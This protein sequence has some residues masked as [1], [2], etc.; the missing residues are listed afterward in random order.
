MFKC[1]QQYLKTKINLLQ[2]ERRGQENLKNDLVRRIKMLEFALR[3]ERGRNSAVTSSNS[4]EIDKA[5]KT[6][7]ETKSDV[8]MLKTAFRLDRARIRQSVA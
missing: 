1:H 8:D 7:D 2:N 6:G 4:D 3:Q 5:G